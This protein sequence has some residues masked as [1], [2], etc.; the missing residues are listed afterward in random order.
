MSMDLTLTEQKHVRTALRFLRLRLGASAVAH[1]L[2][3]QPDT[4]YRFAHGTRPLTPTPAFRVAR[5]AEIAMEDL[6]AGKFVPEG[7]CPHCGRPPDFAD[8]TTIADRVA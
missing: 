2:R 6:L 4:L 5:L 7:T 8:E 3:F 1:A